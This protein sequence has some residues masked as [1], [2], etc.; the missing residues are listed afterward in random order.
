MK[1]IRNSVVKIVTNKCNLS[2]QE[3]I[4]PCRKISK[5]FPKGKK[6]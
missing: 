6:V 3:I 4:N 5:D 1:V 2:T